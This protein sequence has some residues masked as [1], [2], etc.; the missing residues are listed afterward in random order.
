MD[1]DGDE[2]VDQQEDDVP[3]VPVAAAA[4][5][6]LEDDDDDDGEHLGG[7]MGGL[8]GAIFGHGGGNEAEEDALDAIVQ[9]TPQSLPPPLALLPLPPPKAGFVLREISLSNLTKTTRP[10]SPTAHFHYHHHPLF[11]SSAA[12]AAAAA[13]AKSAAYKDASFV[14]RDDMVHLLLRHMPPTVERLSLARNPHLHRPLTP[15]SEPLAPHLKEIVLDGCWRVDMYHLRAVEA[16]RGTGLYVDLLHECFGNG[17]GAQ[18]GSR[19]CG[20]KEVVILNGKHR[21]QWVCCWIIHKAGPSRYHVKVIQTNK[22]DNAVGF[23]DRAAL[24]ISRKHL[25]HFCGRKEEEEEG[26]KKA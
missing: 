12:A 20:M 22:F 16:A 19:P 7:L 6:A 18:G 17:R 3:V 24:D 10:G 11:P 25:R 13:T 23:S 21:G 1:D 14:L 5:V 26:G 2:D 8:G 9:L 15:L 4:N